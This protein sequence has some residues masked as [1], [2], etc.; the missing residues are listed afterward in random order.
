MARTIDSVLITEVS[1]VISEVLNREVPLYL[2]WEAAGVVDA[3][4]SSRN[5][6]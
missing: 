6:C 4:L 3:Q 5:L 1:L 2:C